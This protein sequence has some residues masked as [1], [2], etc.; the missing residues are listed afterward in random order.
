MPPPVPAGP[1][2]LEDD[3]APMFVRI[4]R[5]IERA[6]VAGRW[7]AGQRLPGARAWAEALGVHR[8]TVTR[9]LD[10]LALGGWVRADERRGVFVADSLPAAERPRRGS[11]T[12]APARVVARAAEPALGPPPTRAERLLARHEA[13]FGATPGTLSLGGGVPDLHAFPREALARAYRRALRDG[14]PALLDYG[15]PRG[16][17]R[18]REALARFLGETRALAVSPDEILVT[19]GA[20]EALFLVGELLPRRA[21]A[22]EAL[23][24]PPAWAALARTRALVGVPV[25]ADGV[26]VDALE[27]LT[28]R[29]RLGALY[30]TP[31]HQYP[32]MVTLP[33]PARLA[34]LGVAERSGLVLVEDDYDHELHFAGRPI[35]PIAS[36][37]PPGRVL[38]VG[39]LSKV[40][41]PGLRLGFLVAPKAT[42]ERAAAIRR[43]ID[44]QGE[45]VLEH[46]VAE[47]FE[48]GEVERHVRRMRERYAA[49]RTLFLELLAR[50]LGDTL[51]IDVPAGGMALWARI[52]DGVD[53]EAWADRARVAG[54]R[55][56]PGRAFALDGRPVAALRLGFGAVADAA[57]AGAVARLAASRPRDRLR[58]ARPRRGEAPSPRS[59]DEPRIGGQ[60]PSGRALHASARS[61]L[62]SRGR[63]V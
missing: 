52:V 50:S 6:L 19:R 49:R 8:N 23:G 14:G 62:A 33:G 38:Y 53:A 63:R 29:R 32:T 10:E 44:R 45:A 58:T 26:D 46:A 34:L 4:A 1:L 56:T 22:V 2:E 54:V 21:L 11:A 48:R 20:Q 55:V 24:Y 57:L 18:L 12:R 60:Q 13:S 27:R 5:A 40:L 51:S 59:E 36:Q 30:L 15:D 37:A 17:R 9:A 39:T 35:A 16:A 61:R 41:A 25:G 43:A 28:R 3:A 31:H 7:R 42:I 47:L